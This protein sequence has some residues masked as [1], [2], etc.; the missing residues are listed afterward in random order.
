VRSPLRTI[1]VPLDGSALAQQ[2]L[3]TAMHIARRERADVRLVM[4]APPVSTFSGN[5]G[6]LSGVLPGEAALR[7]SLRQYLDEQADSC[8]RIDA[9]IRLSCIVLEG[10]T[11]PA[12]AQHAAGVGVDLIVMTTHGWGGFKR[13]WLGSVTEALIHLAP[14]PTLVLPQTIGSATGLRRVLVALESE[15][16]ADDLLQPALELG[17]MTSGTRYT[18]LQVIQLKPSSLLRLLGVPA[19]TTAD[20]VQ[21]MADECAGQL[22]HI[23]QRLRHRGICADWHMVIERDASEQILRLAKQPEY[24]LIVVGTRGHGLERLLFGSVSTKVVRGAQDMVLVV[25]LEMND[26]A[27]SSTESR[28]AVQAAGSIP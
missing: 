3:P 20:W 18:L 27:R 21:R 26:A 12:L 22:E 13:F 17:G 4:V 2:A 5:A 23:A 15:R 28:M 25:P 7:A 10:P 19:A 11:A 24:D 1:M 16:D 9:S 6:Q 8:R 14:C